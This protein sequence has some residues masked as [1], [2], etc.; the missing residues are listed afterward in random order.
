MQS[1]ERS[2]NQKETR[3]PNL[4]LARLSKE[5]AIPEEEILARMRWERPLLSANQ[6]CS[7][8]L[9]LPI[10]NCQPT[11]ACS[12]FCYAS[13]G[14]Q[15]FKHSVIKSLAVNRETLEDPEQAAFKMAAEAAG[16]PIR[17][18]GSGELLPD[19]AALVR[20]LEKYRATSWGFTR[21]IDTHLVLPNLMFSL[22]ATTPDPVL[23]YV[24]ADVPIHRRS[25]LRRPGDEACP[26]EVAVTFPVHGSR[27]NHVKKISE[28][29]TD[30]PGV[31][32]RVDGCWECRRCF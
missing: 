23:E 6:K 11:Q 31:R 3:Q 7:I 9:D 26:F 24:E 28:E 15:M 12:Q 13:Q 1:R 16:R 21:R 8:S 32:K 2:V 10:Q 17:L 30:C 20:Y 27:T 29:K 18:A 22:D 14:R 5:V 4:Y 25:Y 19:H